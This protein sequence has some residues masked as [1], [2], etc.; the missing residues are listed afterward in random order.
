MDVIYTLGE[1]T[2]TDVLARLPDPPGNAS[3]RV[4]LRTLEEK[5]YLTH[6][7]EGRR[8]VYSA[9]ISPEK[10]KH[11]MVRHMVNVFFG[12]STPKAVAAML[13]MSAK[14]L[15]GEDLNHLSEIIE[16][17]RNERGNT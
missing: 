12:G 4:T 17:A 2:A 16:Q 10:A 13:N 11:S 1:A 8:Y 15:S 3:V 9:A 7:K 14:E 5:G 6:R